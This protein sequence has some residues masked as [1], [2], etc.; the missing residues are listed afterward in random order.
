MTSASQRMVVF[1]FW[2]DNPYLNQLYL[3]PIAQG[4][5]ITRVSAFDG[6]LAELATLAAGDLVHLH[7]TGPIVQ[8]GETEVEGRERRLT[9]Q[10][11]VDAAID[12]GARLIWTVHNAFPH[13][14]RYRNEELELIRFL[15]ARASTIHVLSPST[16]D[17]VRVDY[18]LDESKIVSVPHSSYWGVYDQTIGRAESRALLGLADDDLAIVFVGQMR[19]YKGIDELLATIGVLVQRDP[20]YTLI[21]A[22]KTSDD[23]VRTI[24]DL[25]PA[26]ARVYREHRFIPDEEVPRWLCAGDVA[27]LPYRNVL[28]S[29]SIFLAATFGLPVVV[30]DQ[31]SLRHDF[32][33]EPWV[34][35]A[36]SDGG[37]TA[38][39][40][41]VERALNHRETAGR[42]AEAWA[43]THTPWAMSR[44]F[45][46]DVIES[47]L[48][49]RAT[50]V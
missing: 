30:P 49:S 25:V 35:F 34:T 26:N 31:P 44:R 47:H 24:D 18:S 10:A 27:V 41:A 11:A 36:A 20:R 4:L 12:R 14:M 46:A 42:S 19:P 9:F 48:V 8:R 13:E 33:A 23:D 32:G 1:P 2:T 6:L 17:V 15:D 39:A 43:R 7:W 28:N 5:E 38:I 37:P 50:A 40:D 21:M 29:G 22:G 3:A 45:A 16:A